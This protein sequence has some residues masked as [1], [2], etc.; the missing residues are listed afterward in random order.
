M[1]RIISSS[2]IVGTFRKEGHEYEVCVSAEGNY[3][4]ERCQLVMDLESCVR[5]LGR[6][7]KMDPGSSDW[8]PKP[9]SVKESVPLD[10]AR[11]AARDVF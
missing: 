8:L 5:P 9:Q 11:E 6:N 2:E 7:G 10:E 1:R 4:D 3:D